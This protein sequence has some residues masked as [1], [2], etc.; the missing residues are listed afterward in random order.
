MQGK[1]LIVDPIVTNR[2]VLKVKLASAFYTV[3]QASTMEEATDIAISEGPDLILSALDLPDGSAA[4]LCR[5]LTKRPQTGQIPIL[6]L[7]GHIDH[8]T[9]IT[10]LEAGVHDVL[11]KPYD[12]TLL[13]CRVRSL[14][15][16]YNAEAEW[17]F[18]DDTT[19]ALGFAEPDVPFGP[20][21]E[22]VLVGQDKTTIQPWAVTLRPLLGAALTLASST[23]V[24]GE[25]IKGT[26]PDVY[27]LVIEAKKSNPDGSLRLISALRANARSRHA[28]ILVLQTTPDAALAAHALDLGADDLMPDG[29]DAAELAL[30]LK[31]L[32]RRKRMSEKLR[33]TVRTGLRAAVFDPL[34]GLHNR[35]YA[36]PHLVRVAEQAHGTGRPYAVM[37][38]DLDHF[39]RIND[40]F[41]HASG[42][43]V[44]V[45]V[46]ER[47]RTSLRSVDMVARIGGEEFMIVMPGTTLQEAR[48]TA[49]R[50]CDTIGGRPFDLPGSATP[51]RITISI[52][53]A[54]DAMSRC[55]PDFA[56]PAISA[57][58]TGASLMEQADKALYAA[59]MKG[60]NQVKLSRP[61]A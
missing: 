15:R 24:M 17:L 7:A 51:V 39:K 8:A 26:A 10:A 9:R 55:L 27:V 32:L 4:D 35:R 33:Q 46:A 44:L 18:R 37:L 28:G 34:T 16:A 30:R 56:D 38:C 53:M 52:G 43:A 1:I 60:R 11:V 21:G 36:M 42:D 23:E 50:L 3:I 29:F 22:F 45:E 49:L 40:V 59:K 12:E 54:L 2:I 58:E 19:R 5:Q 61:A 57:Q 6:A 13:L 47:L 31:S 25:G 20:Q 14:I 41:G 48:Q